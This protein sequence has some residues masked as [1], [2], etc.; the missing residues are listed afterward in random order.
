MNVA[1]VEGR[2]CRK[3]IRAPVYAGVRLR[4]ACLRTSSIRMRVTP[5]YQ[6]SKLSTVAP[7][8]RCSRRMLTGSRVPLNTQAP[9]AHSATRSSKSKAY[10]FTWEIQIREELPR[11]S[12]RLPPFQKLRKQ[13]GGR[14]RAVATWI[15][16]LKLAL[17]KAVLSSHGNCWRNS[18]K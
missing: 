1:E 11:P 2:H 12:P 14:V 13:V 15:R 3:K 8:S 4:S 5:S 18:P 6:S 9:L 7:A 16:L 10:A 17:H